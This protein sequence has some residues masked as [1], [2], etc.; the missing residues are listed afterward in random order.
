VRRG[1]GRG[2]KKKPRNEQ[3]SSLKKGDTSVGKGGD[4]KKPRDEQ[5]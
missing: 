3:D 2:D 4:K 5:E 1:D